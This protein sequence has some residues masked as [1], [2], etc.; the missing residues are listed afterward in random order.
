[1]AELDA[2]R[3][4]WIVVEERVKQEYKELSSVQE[5]SQIAPKK[6]LF[7]TKRKKPVIARKELP[8]LPTDY[9]QRRAV[10]EK[11]AE[12]V[13]TTAAALHEQRQR[14]ASEPRPVQPDRSMTRTP[15]NMVF[16]NLFT[17]EAQDAF[18]W[19]SAYDKHT[20]RDTYLNGFDPYHSR[21]PSVLQS[22]P[23]PSNRYSSRDF[24]RSQLGSSVG[25]IT[26]DEFSTPMELPTFDSP[27]TEN[28]VPRKVINEP[29]PNRLR[30]DPRTPPVPH[31]GNSFSASTPALLPISPY[32]PPM[33]K[34]GQAAT[35][36]DSRRASFSSYQPAAPELRHR[37]RAVSDAHEKPKT[38]FWGHRKSVSIGSPKSN[39]KEKP[40]TKFV[41]FFKFGRR[42]RAS[43]GVSRS[44]HEKT[45]F[46]KYEARNREMQMQS[47]PRKDFSPLNAS[48]ASPRSKNSLEQMFQNSPR[49]DPR[50]SLPD[51]PMG[52][53]NSN[54]Y[55]MIETEV[56]PVNIR[57]LDAQNGLAILGNE[58]GSD[59]SS[60]I[61]AF[62]DDHSQPILHGLAIHP[63][64]GNPLNSKR[65][66][67]EGQYAESIVPL[68][69]DAKERNS[70]LVPSPEPFSTPSFQL[71]KSLEAYSSVSRNGIVDEEG[72][73]RQSNTVDHN[74]FE[75][76]SG[77]ERDD[78][79]EGI[80]S[81]VS[82]HYSNE[83]SIKTLQSVSL[84]TPGSRS[85]RPG[86]VQRTDV[87]HQ[88]QYYDTEEPAN[89]PSE[90]G[91]EWRD[92][93]TSD[94]LQDYG[95]A[96]GPS[97]DG[98]A[99][100][101]TDGE[102][103][104]LM[105][106]IANNGH[107]SAVVT[108]DTRNEAAT[109][110]GE[111]V[112]YGPLGRVS[113]K[114]EGFAKS[115]VNGEMDWR[116]APMAAWPL[117]ETEE[118]PAARYTMETTDVY[119]DDTA[120]D[121]TPRFVEYRIEGRLPL[122]GLDDSA[123]NTSPVKEETSRMAE[124]HPGEQGE[125][126]D[127]SANKTNPVKEELS[128]MTETHLGEQG[129]T[130][131]NSANKTS[132]V[133]EELS[134]MTETH[135]G[136]QGE[137]YDNSANTTSPVEETS[138]MTE[139]HPGEQEETLAKMSPE[140]RRTRT[141]AARDRWAYIRQNASERAKSSKT[142][143][144]SPR[145]VSEEHSMRGSSGSPTSRKVSRDP[146]LEDPDTSDEENVDVKI[147]RIKARVAHLTGMPA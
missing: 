33:P 96:D 32:T 47:S 21:E 4:D 27:F 62:P 20:Q 99:K 147:A 11:R 139:T 112:D 101:G 129:E 85:I 68:F 31:K 146:A 54:R 24:S 133:K 83:N 130:Y 76:Q 80:E 35:A 86:Q 73:L 30:F 120:P 118:E 36:E 109:T 42:R 94:I 108:D 17:I 111:K 81:V 78:L 45:P 56:N 84:E 44:K 140:T 82:R 25:S 144:N 116:G 138:R 13:Q 46:E 72:S 100:D 119:Q 107:L 34:P 113:N 77:V 52:E 8:P 92:S 123:N 12:R 40:F 90:G 15:S 58:E 75:S 103:D 121:D 7:S 142:K 95:A 6:K 14:T 64:Q 65:G 137:T 1:V 55:G 70:E 59:A 57:R 106:H 29:S 51:P 71:G 126:Y 10:S 50:K 128:R 88:S 66:S 37:P 143:G 102:T 49:L 114:V 3:S 136:E 5:R 115:I 89:D 131:D 69:Y 28:S 19:T 61:G 74:A 135:L 127:N 60:P 134:R 132:P 97:Q 63:T 38:T 41:N 18:K 43:E 53:G 91:Q 145:R 104:A 110:Q 122:D 9:Q 22:L 124:N 48:T 87:N 117:N 2:P 16:N 141:L 39:E 79:K 105:H 98:H 67:T 23:S 125:T 26:P 93:A